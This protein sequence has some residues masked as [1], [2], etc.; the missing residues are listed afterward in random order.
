MSGLLTI[1][2]LAIVAVSI[3]QIVT[4]CRQWRHLARRYPLDPRTPPDRQTRVWRAYV[5][6]FFRPFQH[7]RLAWDERGIFLI[8]TPLTQMTGFGPLYLPRLD[9]ETRSLSRWGADWVELKPTDS[10]CPVLFISMRAWQK[11]GLPLP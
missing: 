3:W 7:L 2:F 4:T 1:A 5:G 9:I 6:S 11:S 8:P 10:S